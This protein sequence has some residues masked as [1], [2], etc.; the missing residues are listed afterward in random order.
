MGYYT[1]SGNV[2]GDGVLA[3]N[4]SA[5][6]DLRSILLNPFINFNPFTLTNAGATGPIGPT[7]AQCQAA[8]S[9]DIY[10][11]L[12]VNF[13]YQSYTIETPGTYRFTL[14]GASGG[15]WQTSPMSASTGASAPT[16]DGYKRLPGATVIGE[17]SLSIGDVITMVIGQ[18]GGDDNDADANCPGAGGGTFVTLGTFSNI[19][20]AAD[21]LLFV[22]GGGAGIGYVNADNPTTNYSIGVGQ[23]GTSGGTTANQAGGTNGNGSPTGQQTSNSVGGGGYLNGPGSNTTTN[24]TYSIG[25]AN[26]VA[27]GFRKGATG[28]TWTANSRGFGGFG[29][30][31]QGAA[32]SAS[33]D[34]KGG[35]GGYS[36]G[37]HGFDAAES[38]GGGGSYAIGTATNTSF[39]AGG[40]TTNR[41]GSVY[42]EIV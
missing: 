19:Q 32:T 23:A 5:V 24:F 12:S 16:I 4:K 7:L 27:A 13:G 21:T 35:G 29:G 34:D 26:R 22:A 20:S 33:D 2:I 10:D 17:Y 15:V 18:G 41:H 28:G 8:Y 1:R 25:N 9:A 31:G 11:K 42:L 3:S 37:G 36:G 40:N 39:T 30:G 14:K 6:Y 38:G